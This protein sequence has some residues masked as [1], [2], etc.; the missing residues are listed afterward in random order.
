MIGPDDEAAEQLEALG[1]EERA[2]DHS[3]DPYEGIPDWPFVDPLPGDG[4]IRRALAYL[5]EHATDPEVAEPVVLRALGDALEGRVWPEVTLAD[6]SNLDQRARLG[7]AP[8]KD[9]GRE[10]GAMYSNDPTRVEA[11]WQVE[12]LRSRLAEV[13]RALLAHDTDAKVLADH[14]N[15]A[16]RLTL[17][18]MGGVSAAD[19]SRTATKRTVVLNAIT[20]V[21]GLRLPAVVRR[22]AE[23]GTL[24]RERLRRFLRA[25][26]GGDVECVLAL[27]RARSPRIARELDEEVGPDDLIQRAIDN[28]RKP[29]KGQRRWT[30]LV[31]LMDILGLW[32]EATVAGLPAPDEIAA[33]TRNENS[34]RVTYYDD[35]DSL[36]NLDD[37]ALRLR[38][39]DRFA[40]FAVA[41]G[42]GAPTVVQ[43][44]AARA[45]IL[46]S[47]VKP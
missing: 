24:D 16:E 23:E 19:D 34:L 27:V 30:V 32:K 1:D 41:V 35:E 6:L 5:T 15:L 43:L 45:A 36:G 37:T 12:A 26:E 2:A 9:E 31:S 28:Y 11:V 8:T 21:A 47:E 22:L 44:E 7:E 18:L 20:A 10:F 4:R 3:F 13:H 42:L 39:W 46:V 25:L 40:A 29:S 38:A 14:I 33:R 17:V